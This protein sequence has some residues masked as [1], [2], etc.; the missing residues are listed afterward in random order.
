MEWAGEPGIARKNPTSLQFRIES[1][2]GEDELEQLADD[3]ISVG[4]ALKRGGSRRRKAL[5]M[6]TGVRCCPNGVEAV[7]YGSAR[8][9]SI[10]LVYGCSTKKHSIRRN[11][12]K[13]LRLPTCL[14]LS[15]L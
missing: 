14:L 15:A 12:H 7:N 10:V 3:M 8:G 6:V 2:K 11:M 9:N 1:S 13:V 4:R 5:W